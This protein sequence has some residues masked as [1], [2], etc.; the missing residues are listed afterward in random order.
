MKTYRPEG[1]HIVIRYIV[2]IFVACGCIGLLQTSIQ[3]QDVKDL[4]KQTRSAISASQRAMFSRK[5]EEAQEQLN[6]AA[7]MIQ[8]IKTADPEYSQLTT[9]EN[10]YRKQL[11]DLEKRLPKKEAAEPTPEPA[12][13]GGAEAAQDL[14]A[15][16]R[17]ANNALS[18]SQRVMFNRKFEEAQAELKK[19]AELIAQIK[20]AD[21]TFSQLKSLESKYERQKTDLEKR[22]PKKE[23]SS[24]AASETQPASSEPA[25]AKLPSNVVYYLK[26]VDDIITQNEQ[27]FEGELIGSP[28][29]YIGNLESALK[30]VNETMDRIFKTYG[31]KFDHEHPDVKARQEKIAE[32]QAKI[33]E[34]KVK[35]AVQQSQAAKIEVQRNAQS[36]KWLQKIT[37]Y[38]TGVGQSGYDENSYLIGSGTSN[39][40]ELVHRK[41]IYAKAKVLFD[42]YQQIEFPHGKTQALEMAEDELDRALKGF[43]KGYQESIDRFAQEAV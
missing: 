29:A 41:M 23:T 2:I 1:F 7:E 27:T 8:Q 35:I 31:D 11:K 5:F 34:F 39:V 37:P 28:D 18:A 14:N 20:A 15:L 12:E 21:S 19:A 16:A 9:L 36:E 33:E 26:Q 10:Q 17:Q 25:T 13:T 32:F 42:E 3:A 6:K 43:E 30:R 38:I 22:L 40:D 4:A 24:S